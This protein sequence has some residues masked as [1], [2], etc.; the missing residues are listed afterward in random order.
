[1]NST[2]EKLSKDIPAL[3][4]NNFIK[5]ISDIKSDELMDSTN[6]VIQKYFSLKSVDIK[7]YNNSYFISEAKGIIEIIKV[8]LADPKYLGD[9]I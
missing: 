3:Y 6:C 8:K 7:D 5:I 2:K 1:M 9:K 4:I